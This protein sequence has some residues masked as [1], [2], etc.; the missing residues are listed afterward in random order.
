V[1]YPDVLAR[2]AP[3]VLAALRGSDDALEL[4]RTGLPASLD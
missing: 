1:D 4:C 3:A 2:P